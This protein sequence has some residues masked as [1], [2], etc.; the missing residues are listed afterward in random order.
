ME[1]ISLSLDAETLIQLDSIQAALGF[2]S[3]SKLIR[4]TISSLLNEHKMMESLK[5][6]LDSVFVVT[7]KESEKHRVSDLLHKF[8]DSIKTVVHQHH[9]GICLEVLI[10]C[11]DASKIRDLYAVLKRDKSVRSVSCSVL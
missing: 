5:G 3:R 2:K 6:H 10:V 11:S 4:A 1:I 9:V 8:E 7:Y